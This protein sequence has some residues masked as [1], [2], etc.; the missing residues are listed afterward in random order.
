MR[1][2]PP[3]VELASTPP[4]SNSNAR[5]RITM[6]PILPSGAWTAANRR[7]TRR[8]GPYRHAAHS[9]AGRTRVARRRVAWRR[10]GARMAEAAGPPVVDIYTD[11]ACSG[12]PGPGGWGAVLLYGGHEK[13]LHG[14]DPGRPRTT[15]WS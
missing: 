4:K 14:G 13:E 9:A 10:Y 2:A 1:S 11:G 15:G 7:P 8:S 5:G 6:G 3:P 12:N